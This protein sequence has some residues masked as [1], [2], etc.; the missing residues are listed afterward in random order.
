MI[1]VCA[2]CQRFMG[3]KEPLDDPSVTHGICPTCSLRQQMTD[4][5]TLVISRKRSEALPVLQAL[6]RGT[7]EIR[8][9]LDRRRGERR[10]GIPPPG[11]HERRREGDRRRGSGLLLV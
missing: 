5:P 6:L 10:R 11:P 2:W 7:P 8:I 9:V 3:Q 4:V 1:T